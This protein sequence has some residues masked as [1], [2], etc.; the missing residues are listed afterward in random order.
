M[1]DYYKMH[2]FGEIFPYTSQIPKKILSSM[3]LSRI[4]RK[5]ERYKFF[6]PYNTGDSVIFKTDNLNHI[7]I[8]NYPC[9]KWL[10][11]KFDNIIYKHIK[12][13]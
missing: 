7:Q 10:V 11:V 4:S 12:R 3:K 6:R 1:Q 9:N 5:S 8:N 2:V 13:G